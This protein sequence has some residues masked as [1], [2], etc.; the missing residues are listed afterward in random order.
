MKAYFHKTFVLERNNISKVLTFVSANPTADR[1][2][3]AEETGIGIGRNVSDGKV[4]PTIQYAIYTG[5]L[6]PDSA[7]SKNDIVLSDVGKTIFSVDPSLKSRITQWLMHYFLCREENEALVWSYFVHHFLQEHSEFDGETLQENLRQHFDDLSDANIKDYR[8]ILISCYIDANALS[9]VGL[10]ESFEKNKFLRG[11]VHY[12]NPYLAAYILAEIWQ[13][14]HPERS[15]VGPD[16]LMQPG[17]LASTLNLNHGDLQNC[18]DEMS[19]V[20]AIRQMREAPPFQVIR[21][22]DDK[23]DLLRRAY[24][25]E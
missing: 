18:L 21:S 12:P 23:S 6:T 24:E 2:S 11:G 13:A 9:K 10:I 3:I 15:M 25:E 4:R 16:T 20:G 8:R 7:E 22:W 17:H 1:Q 14:K 19:G 5:L